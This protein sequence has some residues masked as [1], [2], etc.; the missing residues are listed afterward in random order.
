PQ[1]CGE[2]NDHERVMSNLFPT[3]VAF[4][5]QRI[6][7]FRCFIIL[8]PSTHPTCGCQE[9]RPLTILPAQS[10]T[11][12]R[13]IVRAASLFRLLGTSGSTDGSLFVVNNASYDFRSH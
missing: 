13:Y 1:W 11:K 10:T 6:N 8:T 2:C 5:L 3:L 7:H 4:W 9:E 12:L